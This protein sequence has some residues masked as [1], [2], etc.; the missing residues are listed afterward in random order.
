MKKNYLYA[1]S[2]SAAF[3]LLGGVEANAQSGQ[4]HTLTAESVYRNVKLNWKKPTE[5][6]TLQW[7]DGE[8][9]NGI[10]GKTHDP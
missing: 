8:D 9:Y 3:A 4:P 7:H 2:A 6:I 5:K 10:D 1:F